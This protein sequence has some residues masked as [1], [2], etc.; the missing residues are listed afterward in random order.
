MGYRRL[1]L[2]FSLLFALCLPAVAQLPSAPQPQI[3]AASTINRSDIG[4]ASAHTFSTRV[5]EVNVVFTVTNGRDRFVSNLNSSEVR[6]FD[7]GEQPASLTYFLHQADVPLKIALLIDIS[8]SVSDFFRSQQNAALIFLQQTLR[9]ADSAAVMV[10]GV[11]MRVA[12]SFTSNLGTLI[13]AIG[14]LRAD[15]NESTAIYDAVKSSCEKLA[16]NDVSVTRRALIV[17]TDG[18]DNMS[19]HS[20]Q[21][22]INTA[23]ETEVVV[24]ALNTRPIASITDP[25]LKKLTESTGG[26]VLHARDAKQL[27]LAFA[28]VNEQ[29]RN[30]YLLGYKPPHW[31]ADHSFHKIRIG[32][33]RHGLQIHCRKGYYAND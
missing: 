32:T 13:G 23:L 7:N 24:F 4:V 16:E 12:Q 6:V 3:S 26:A 29:L 14:G 11:Q 5:R 17:I 10:F 28:K 21:D 2:A 33:S 18:D 8:A 22:A 25:S 19:R 30:Q 27:R 31:Q 1:K 9:P 15:N 20:I